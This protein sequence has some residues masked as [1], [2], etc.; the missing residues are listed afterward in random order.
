MGRGSTRGDKA[1]S[2]RS[3]CYGGKV[4]DPQP[5]QPLLRQGPLCGDELQRLLCLG[6]LRQKTGTASAG[7]GE[8]FLV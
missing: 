5:L 8:R 2:R 1:L 3:A 6:P 7:P 4:Q